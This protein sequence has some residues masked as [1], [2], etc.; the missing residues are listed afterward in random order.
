MAGRLTGF[1]RFPAD[2]KTRKRNS[3]QP[4]GGGAYT[5]LLGEMPPK[6]CGKYKKILT[7]IKN[8]RGSAAG[9]F[10]IVVCNSVE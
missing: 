7:K 9:Y 8:P 10:K 5:D 2:G 3:E 1:R 4:T 6:F